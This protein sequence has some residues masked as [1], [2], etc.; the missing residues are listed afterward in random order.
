MDLPGWWSPL[1]KEAPKIDP[2]SP[3]GRAHFSCK[4]TS[5]PPAEWTA[6]FMNPQ[7]ETEFP[8]EKLRIEGSHG[9]H[10]FK[11]M[12]GCAEEYLEK[13]VANIDG[14]IQSANAKYEQEVV[15]KIVEDSKRAVEQKDAQSQ[16]IEELQRRADQL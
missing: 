3:T 4:L 5:D 16:R 8:P 13:C 12:G 10:G 6:Y 2:S 7:V 1:G 11:I 14:R 15:P 9:V